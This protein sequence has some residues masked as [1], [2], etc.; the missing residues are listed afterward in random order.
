MEGG[1]GCEGNGQDVE[2]EEN[3][4]YDETKGRKKK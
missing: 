1:G 3:R 4:G 2:E